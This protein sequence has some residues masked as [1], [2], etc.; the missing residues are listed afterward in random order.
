MD[1]N[2]GTMG[3]RT[4]MRSAPRA[5]RRRLAGPRR[6][7]LFTSVG[8]LI[9]SVIVLRF[10]LVSVVIAGVVVGV[11]FLLGASGEFLIAAAKA[12]RGREGV[13]SAATASRD[14]DGARAS[15][16]AG[17]TVSAPQAWFRPRGRPKPR[18]V[19]WHGLR[20]LGREIRHGHV[21]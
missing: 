7:F 16:D 6:V 20:R 2:P 14:H 3:E 8:W 18:S 21:A 13:G 10:A 19:T 15:P 5:A 17:V 11:V 4:G 12:R 9:I 1:I